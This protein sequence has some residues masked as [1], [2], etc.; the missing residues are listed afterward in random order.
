MQQA[1]FIFAVPAGRDMTVRITGSSLALKVALSPQFSNHSF[2]ATR[3]F[4]RMRMY[5]PYRSIKGLPA[6]NPKKQ[7]AIEPILQPKD[8]AMVT[9]RRLVPLSPWA[10][11]NPAKGMTISLG[12]GMQALSSAMRNMMPRYW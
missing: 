10:T 4:S 7:A 9:P 11:R 5:F 8:P 6:W 2:A 1:K 3:C 12:T